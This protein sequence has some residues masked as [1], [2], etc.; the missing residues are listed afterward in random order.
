MSPDEVIVLV[1]SGVVAA[2]AWFGWY[3]RALRINLH[4]TRGSGRVHLLTAPMIAVAVI[5]AVLRTLAAQ[6][7]RDDPRYL[8]L[9]GALGMAWVGVGA[10]CLPLAGISPRDDVL[11]GGNRGA[12]YAAAGALLA[13]ALC[14]A[15]GNVG[16]GPGWWV[17]LF[18]AG[19]A[20]ASIVAVWLILEALSAISDAITIDRDA[21]AGMRLGGFLV[22]CGAIFGRAAA[23]D[24]VSADATVRDFLTVAPP[25]LLL[26]AAAVVLE[27]VARP[28]PARPAPAVVAFGAAP[29]LGYI[30]LA[31]LYLL[32]LGAPA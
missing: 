20:T 12:A 6:D 7:V 26:L 4:R 13:L 14:Y 27:R 24:W 3:L 1:I 17:V 5:F 16:D 28:T 18:S 23:G 25:A 11:E 32:R 29:A 31:A 19:L 10:W 9:Y 21:A 2:W 8:A 30:G 22:A 15:G